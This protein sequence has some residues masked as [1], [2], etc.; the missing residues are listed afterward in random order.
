MKWHEIIHKVLTDGGAPLKMGGIYQAIQDLGLE[1]VHNHKL[2]KCQKASIRVMVHNFKTEGSL[3]YIH[4]EGF[5]GFYYL[6]HWEVGPTT[7][8][9]KTLDPLKRQYI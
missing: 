5:G 2:D 9:Q 1:F 8:N 4:H 7:I 6:P 3:L